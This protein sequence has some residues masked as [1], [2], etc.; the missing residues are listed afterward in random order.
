MRS[1]TVIVVLL[2]LC[3]DDGLCTEVCERGSVEIDVWLSNAIKTQLQLVRRLPFCLAVLLGTHN[4]AITLADGYANRDEYFQLY[5]KWIRWVSSDSTLRTND[6][7]FSLTDQLN[8]GVRAVELD[9][10]W[11]EGELRIAHC[12][13]F[14]AA[15]FNVLIRAV[16]VVASLLGH[17]I[18]WDTETVGCNPSLSSIPVTMQRSFADA[19]AELSTWLALPENKEEFLVVFLDD[20]MDLQT[21]GFL[22]QLMKEIQDGFPAGSI[23]TPPDHAKHGNVLWPSINDLLLDGK[24][25]M[26]VSGEDYGPAMAPLIFERNNGTV[27]NWQEP[28]LADFDGTPDCVADRRPLFPGDRHTL[29]GTLFRV[30][31]CELLYGPLNCNFIWK[32][33]N[34][35]ILDELSLPAVAACGVNMPC[36]DLLTP[37]RAA[38][39]IW[40]WAPGEPYGIAAAHAR[41]TIWQRALQWLAVALS[42]HPDSSQREAGYWPMGKGGVAQMAQHLMCRIT[43]K[44]IWRFRGSSRDQGLRQ[45][46]YRCKTGASQPIS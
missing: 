37:E 27:C 28:P 30:T 23:Y 41:P 10:H 39:T 46:G 29:T 26:F 4:S 2:H 38:A 16:N 22:P 14:H 9:T 13:G 7:Y 32:S 34:L 45:R 1:L 6:Q 31:T 18:H 24:R 33:D 21:W 43:P 25:V 11:V 19:L 3:D 36:P 17:P 40:S 20:Q 44:R 8:M 35:P 15:P 12:G 42:R 5:F